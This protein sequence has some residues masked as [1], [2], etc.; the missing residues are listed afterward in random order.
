MT[1][2][3]S[4]IVPAY[5]EAVLLTDSIKQLHRS[6]ADATL[7]FEIIIV[8]D[9]SSDTT[10]DLANALAKTLPYVHAL[11]QPNQGI[12]GAFRTGALKATGTYVMLWP[13]DMP[14]TSANLTPYVNSLG[15]SDVIVGA[16]RRRVGYSPIMRF[17][18]WIYPSIVSLLF[19]L[20]LRDVN[21]IQIYR[22]T[23]F[24]EIAPNQRGI[25]MLAE[26]LVRLRDHG[27]S[28]CEVDV[29]MTARTG[30]KPSAG[31]LSVMVKTL[32][33]LFSFWRQW[34]LER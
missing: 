10:G 27:S 4:V 1:I 9:G 20:K 34:R 18:A 17:N 23:H 11:H 16:R 22:R 12:G 5:N 7:T 8:D 13:V 29:D 30:G 26:T 28:F 2:L 25:A 21:W 31:R 14:A 33:G 3:L 15:K 24:L 32:V 6:L 19:D